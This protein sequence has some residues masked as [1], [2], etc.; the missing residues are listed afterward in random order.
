MASFLFIACE[1]E[2]N[3]PVP[4]VPPLPE[5]V[6]LAENTQQFNSIHLENFISVDSTNSEIEFSANMHES[7]IPK[8]GQILLQYSPNEQFPYGFL[9]KV[10]SVTIGA[11]ETKSGDVIK[12]KTGPASIWDAF[13][14]LKVDEEF[15][16]DYT[17]NFPSTKGIEFGKLITGGVAWSSTYHLIF[18]FDSQNKINN[19][20][21]ACTNS[22][23]LHG[24]FNLRLEANNDDDSTYTKT[25]LGPEIPLPAP[26]A[27]IAIKPTI[28]FM[29]GYKLSGSCG[30]TYALNYTT[31]D[32]WTLSYN[33]GLKQ[34]VRSDAT[35]E[36]KTT[37]KQLDQHTSISLDGEVFGGI[38][39]PV[40]LKLFGSEHNKITVEPYGGINLEGKIDINLV[41]R[42]GLYSLFKETSIEPSF[43]FGVGA[44][45]EFLRIF[46]FEIAKV[47]KKLSLGE[48]YLFPEFK[49]NGSIDDKTSFVANANVERDVLFPLGVG[50][51]IYNKKRDG[52]D[53]NTPVQTSQHTTYWL[54]QKFENP[55]TADFQKDSTQEVKPYVKLWNIIIKADWDYGNE[56]VGSWQHILY[57]DS[58]KHFYDNGTAM[59]EEMGNTSTNKTWNLDGNILTITHELGPDEAAIYGSPYSVE[60]L[61]VEFKD[62]DNIQLH[63]NDGGIIGYDE[64]RRI[65]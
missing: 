1:K 58:R 10:E 17:E 50:F 60:V 22:F 19:V 33:N 48:K 51:G 29:Q 27:A 56:L 38:F 18:H 20:S 28:Q 30:F 36:E 14:K 15:K 12:V 32:S 62:H 21:L 43:T 16:L 61:R 9:G 7:Q 35:G 59:F 25:P 55:L 41:E 54:N 52:V 37:T 26:V 13:T 39:L 49:D 34:L 44:E 11:S 3:Q 45:A 64:Y 23:D 6:T 42:E 46:K 2:S 47:E 8:V 4:E 5:N 31:S 65:K 63:Y 53:S 57:E 40:E 24:E